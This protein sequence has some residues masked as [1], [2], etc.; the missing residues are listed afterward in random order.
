ANRHFIPGVRNFQILSDRI[1]QMDLPFFHK[2]HDSGGSELLAHR[3][4]LKN[5]LRFY[6]NLIFKIRK[7]I[8]FLFQD[9]AI[10]DDKQSKT[11][12]LLLF[13]V[14]FNETIDIMIGVNAKRAKNQTQDKREFFH[15]KD[16][17]N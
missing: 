5:S 14:V 12:N 16:Y 9:L 3:S 10:F 15:G 2:K 13:H 17:I 1:I 11:G 6:W 4:G 8:A 7:T